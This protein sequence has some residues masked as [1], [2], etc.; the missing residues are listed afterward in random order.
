MKIRQLTVGP[1]VGATSHESV[2]LFGRGD[3]EFTEGQPR[4]AHGVVR[5]KS[6][7]DAAFGEP[8]FFKL[9][10]NFDMTGVAIVQGLKGSTHYSYQMGWIFSD[11]ETRVIDVSTVLDWADAPVSTFRTGSD[12]D[13]EPRA[14][15][16]GSCR[17]ALRLFGGTW[18]DDRGDKTFGSILKKIEKSGDRVDQLLMCG[19][20]IYADDLN[21]LG[22][23]R[24][25]DEFNARYRR[26]FTTERLRELMSCTPTYMT[27]DD[28]EIED[29]WPE[30][31][32]SKDWVTK[33]PAAIHAYSTYQ[34]SHSPLLPVLDGKLCGTPTHLWYKYK[35]GCCDFFMCD[36]RTERS[37]QE[38]EREMLGPRQ[39]DALLDWLGD[40]SG[41]VKVI[42]TSVPLYEHESDDKWNGFVT[43]RDRILERV[44]AESGLRVVV[45]SG[46]V[47][48]SM[49]SELVVDGDPDF[50]IISVVSSAFFWPYPHPGRRKF[51]LEGEIVTG[52]EIKYRAKNGSEIYPTDAFARL[53]IAQDGVKA[54]F[55]ARKGD[56]LGSKAFDF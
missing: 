29:N 42:I 30:S 47:H 37:L 21:A 28:H 14:I 5:L 40:A 36:T 32:T 27:L 4:R 16:I 18:F 2:R 51:L 31:A 11:V 19:D 54:T 43:Q 6:K 17:Y 35:D 33:F 26:A 39:L 9:N 38:G 45:V 56:E 44:R 53:E 52:T 13:Q 22:A 10:P 55:Y 12:D 15:V 49:A 25:L 3:L 8:I 50:K 20:Q 7:D 1:I 34:G 23:D 48:A 46:D 41:R 24:A